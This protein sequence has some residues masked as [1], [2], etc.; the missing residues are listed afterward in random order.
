MYFEMARRQVY[1]LSGSSVSITVQQSNDLENWEAIGSALTLDAVEA[2]LRRVTDIA[3]KYVRL[4]YT[5]GGE[6][7]RAVIAAGIRTIE[8]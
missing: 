8:L 4:L 7:D 6:F 2:G 3:A 5:L 1:F